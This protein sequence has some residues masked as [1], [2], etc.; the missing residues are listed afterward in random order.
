VSRRFGAHLGGGA[1]LEPGGSVG[2]TML[3]TTRR[4]LTA[5]AASPRGRLLG[6]MFVA[7]TG[8][9]LAVTQSVTV[10]RLD[11][12]AGQSVR[13]SFD[14]STTVASFLITELGA[15]ETIVLITLVAVAVLALL[16]HWHG[17]V[18]LALSVAVTNGVVDVLKVLVSRPR[19]GDQHVVVDAAGFS[20]PSAHAA[21]SMA[22]YG[23]LTFIAARA[24]RGVA[25][26]LIVLGGAML[27]VT[28]GGT[29]IHL[30]A[31]YPIDVLAGW[32]TGGMLVVLSWALVSRLRR[33]PLFAR[34]T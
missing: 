28:V 9:C 10:H 11:A 12:E 5:M 22:L 18:A 25:R 19:P 20:F 33:L 21:V 24:S 2:E 4:L 7:M 13:T 16:R 8:L 23:T 29:R 6:V 15:A 27:V 3:T 34:F 31:H 17:A 32:L 26:V 30:G 14:Q 1:G